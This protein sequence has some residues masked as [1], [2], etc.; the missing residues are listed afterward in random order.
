MAGQ[1][2]DWPINKTVVAGISSG[3]AVATSDIV[4]INKSID[5]QTYSATINGADYE[6]IING[7]TYDAIKLGGIQSPVESGLDTLITGKELIGKILTDSN[8][9]D[10]YIFKYNGIDE[11][12]DPD[13]VYFI[14]CLTGTANSLPTFSTSVTIG[15]SKL[16]R[17]ILKMDNL[18]INY[19]ITSVVF[20]C[21][22]L[23]E[24]SGTDVINTGVIR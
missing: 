24:L 5:L 1:A 10:Y 6:Y 2:V 14:K 4:L 7:V 17:R 18:P 11:N 22:N 12:G 3:E 15:T 9:K 16:G 21:K 23:G 8:G 13:P 20:D 19:R